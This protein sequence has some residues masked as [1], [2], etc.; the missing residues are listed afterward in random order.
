VN[1]LDLAAMATGY[2]YGFSGVTDLCKFDF[3]KKLLR[4]GKN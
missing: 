3:L 2:S 1:D 4:L